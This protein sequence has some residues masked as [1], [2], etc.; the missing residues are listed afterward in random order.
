MTEEFQKIESPLAS[1]N[2]FIIVICNQL[3]EI[4][5]YDLTKNNDIIFDNDS[6]NLFGYIKIT[7]DLVND[8]KIFVKK[9]ITHSN[10][11][12]INIT[13]SNYKELCS[14]YYRYAFIFNDISNNFDASVT[15]AYINSILK[16]IET[17]NYENKTYFI[18]FRHKIAEEIKDNE[19]LKNLYNKFSYGLQIKKLSKNYRYNIIRLISSDLDEAKCIENIRP[20]EIDIIVSGYI[21][22][23]KVSEF[24][25][26]LMFYGKID[27]IQSITI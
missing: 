7:K 21:N 24:F 10:K 5:G 19:T 22:G 18:P 1:F 25:K 2:N 13:L 6:I 15:T 12:I 14:I 11:N 8:I 27:N 26:N 16:D 20:L 4:Y 9:P 3:S 17:N 23:D